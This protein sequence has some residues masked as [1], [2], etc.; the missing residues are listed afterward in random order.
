VQARGRAGDAGGDRFDPEVP[1]VGA[2]DSGGEPVG[3]DTARDDAAI[4][5]SN[6]AAERILNRRLDLIDL[7]VVRL[8]IERESRRAHREWPEVDRDLLS[9]EHDA[10]TERQTGGEIDR[11]DQQVALHEVKQIEHGLRDRRVQLGDNR[12]RRRC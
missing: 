5:A 6:L 1:S 8:L 12:L 10:D 3:H 4:L 11:Q 9:V 7:A 2:D